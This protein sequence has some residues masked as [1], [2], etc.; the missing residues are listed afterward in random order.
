[1]CRED[2]NGQG[3]HLIDG[4][5]TMIYWIILQLNWSLITGSMQWYNRLQTE[6]HLQIA[7]F[8]AVTMCSLV[9]ESSL[10]KHCLDNL[11]SLQLFSRN[12]LSRSAYLMGSDCCLQCSLSYF[13]Y[14][15]FSTLSKYVIVQGIELCINLRLA[16]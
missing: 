16:A 6:V 12:L 1:M 14:G 15:S 9:G 2:R 13:K 5:F 4:I 10:H 8:S 3:L 11:K 7:V